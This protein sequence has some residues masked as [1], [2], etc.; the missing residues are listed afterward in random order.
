MKHF[1]KHTVDLELR[2]WGPFHTHVLY[3]YI[4][5]DFLK[6]CMHIV[7]VT[8]KK[9]DFKGRSRDQKEEYAQCSVLKER[10]KKST[11][12][13]CNLFFMCSNRSWNNRFRD[14]VIYWRPMGEFKRTFFSR[15]GHYMYLF[16][17]RRTYFHLLLNVCPTKKNIPKQYL[18]PQ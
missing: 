15:W 14:H 17:I 16:N 5:I 2:K 7:T 12:Q 1:M 9:L 8:K 11:S 6:Y 10:F 13:L 3:M 4:L 18:K